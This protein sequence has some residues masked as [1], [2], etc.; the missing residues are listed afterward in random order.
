MPSDIDWSQHDDLRTQGLS[1]RERARRLGIA[2]STLR[3]AEKRRAPT[4]QGSSSGAPPGT[5]ANGDRPPGSVLPVPVMPDLT[6][7]LQDLEAGI[8]AYID[9]RLEEAIGPSRPPQV[10]QVL[11]AGP[12][13]HEDPAA[14]VPRGTDERR[15]L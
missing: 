2:E 10:P 15:P 8:T 1:R 14:G 12:H 6:M 7:Q 5:P 3:D 4:A 9:R 11:R 13:P